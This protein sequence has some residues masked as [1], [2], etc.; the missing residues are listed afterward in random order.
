[1]YRKSLKTEIT[2]FYPQIFYPQ[3][4]TDI[5]IYWIITDY[6][7][8]TEFFCCPQII[9]DY[10]RFFNIKDILII[11]DFI[12]ARK[13]TAFFKRHGFWLRIVLTTALRD[14]GLLAQV[15]GLVTFF[16]ISIFQ[17]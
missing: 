9:T 1:M 17:F 3:I 15:H 6:F 13:S 12:L 5:I 14:Y 11:T 16:N 4:S 8:S 2:H 10:H 7:L